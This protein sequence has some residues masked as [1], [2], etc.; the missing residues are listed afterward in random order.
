MTRIVSLLFH[1][2]FARD[3]AESG[4]PG[5]LADAYKHPVT[6]FESVIAEIAAGSPA[7]PVLGLD[8][9][10]GARQVFA[11]TVDDGGVSYYTH[12]A[13]RLEARGWR[14]HAFVATDMIGTPGFLTPAQ[15]RELDARGHLI[16][17]HSCTHPEQMSSLSWDELLWEWR[18][19]CALLSDAVG[20]PITVASVPGGFYSQKVGQAAA[21]SGI[22]VLFTSEPTVSEQI[23]D[24]CR[25]MGRYSVRRSTPPSVV[26]A[27]A[28]GSKWP[29]WQQATIWFL[30]KAAKRLTG[31]WYIPL[32]RI[33]L[34]NISRR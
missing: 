28:V 3:P 20:A 34:D 26:G 13:D 2:L 1:D 25:V 15:I 31:Q 23:V 32:R 16:G 6:E 11:I 7:A 17:S 19:S 9:P 18:E 14:G 21:A 8:R 27:I 22:K 4:F 10:A 33:V 30:N 5:A 24:G 12:L 29:R